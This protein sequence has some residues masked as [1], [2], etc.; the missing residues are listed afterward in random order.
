MSLVINGPLQSP[1][2]ELTSSPPNDLRRR[3]W[4]RRST[5]RSALLTDTASINQPQ[6]LAEVTINKSSSHHKVSS[7]KAMQSSTIASRYAEDNTDHSGCERS[8]QPRTTDHN[9]TQTSSVPVIIRESTCAGD[10][11]NEISS[12]HPIPEDC[13]ARVGHSARRPNQQKENE[14]GER[15]PTI[16]YSQYR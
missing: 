14:E 15:E 16:R 2:A 13:L 12:Q 11:I 3:H 6:A 7:S 9:N 4:R 5:I 1:L 10:I 8:S